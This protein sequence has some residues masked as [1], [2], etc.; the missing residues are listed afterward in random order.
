MRVI[1]GAWR[2]ALVLLL[3]VA[4]STLV[5]A[6]RSTL[7]ATVGR[8]LVA[9]DPLT[10]ADVIAIAPDAQEAGV[11]EASDLVQR[12]I[13]SRVVILSRPVTP[14]A[15][16]FKERGVEYA[17]EGERYLRL[18]HAMNIGEVEIVRMPDGGTEEV[19]E[20]LPEWSRQRQ[21]SSVLVVTGTD[22]SRRMKRV[23]RRNSSGQQPRFTVRR[24]RYSAF[25]PE[26]WWWRRSTVRTAVV[27]LQKLALDVV[28]HPLS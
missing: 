16:H 3:V 15:G 22:H 11:L 17:D 14:I 27:E 10:S 6:V 1:R 13:S 23:L 24:S 9:D 21:L 28:L 8:A 20:F 4:A 25:T 18:L 12:G 5:P 26:R 19:G 2:A 7:L